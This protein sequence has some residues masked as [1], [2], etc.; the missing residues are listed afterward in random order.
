MLQSC[1]FETGQKSNEALKHR[2]TIANFEPHPFSIF[3][4]PVLCAVI[5]A[6]NLNGRFRHAINR[7]V[8]QGVKQNFSRAFLAAWSSTAR[9][10]FQS[11][12]RIVKL[13]HGGLSILRVM[14]FEVIAYV[15]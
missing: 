3:L 8:G 14:L 11:A 1:V 13:P 7:D 2:E 10:L 9:P 4:R 15:L 5:D 6:H 12:D